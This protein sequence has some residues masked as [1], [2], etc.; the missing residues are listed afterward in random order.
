MIRRKLIYCFSL[1]LLAG[2]AITGTGKDIQE[3]YLSSD[4]E[5]YLS[6]ADLA[7]IQPGLQLKIQ[8][9]EVSGSDV[10]VTFRISD[11]QDQPL[12]RLGIETPGSVSTSFL[13][14]RIKPGDTQYTSY[15]TNSVGQASTDAGGSYTSVGDGVYKYKFGTTLPSG[16]PANATH[17][18]GMYAVRDLRELADEIGLFQLAKTG[19]YVAN[20]TFNFVP[21]GGEVTQ[22]RDVVRTGVCNLCHD[23]LALH[24]GSRQKTEVCILCHQPQT[25]DPDTGNTV[26]FKV[27]IHKIHRGASLPSVQAGTPY[28]IIGYRDSVHDYSEIHWPQDTRN[29]TTCH[30][31]GTQ[32]DNWKKNPTRVA[33]GS[34]HDNVN[35]ATGANHVG[36]P[37][38]DDSKCNI[39][40]PADTGLEFD[41]SV[42]G[43]HTIPEFSKQLA[44]VNVKILEV[45]NT[46]PGDKPKV[47]FTVTDNAGKPI[48][49]T[50]LA[51][52]SLRLAGPTTDHKWNASENALTATATSTGYTYTFATNALPTDASGS[53]VVG[54]E[55]AR[56]VTLPGPLLGQSFSVSERAYNP[57][58]YFGVGGSKVVPRRVVVDIKNCNTCHKRLALHGGGRLN[59]DYC[60]TCHNPATTDNPNGSRSAGFNVP[61]GIP[62]QSIN[63]R[64]MIH[65]IH[66]GHDLEND[67]TVYRSRGVYNFNEIHFPGD[68]RNCAK[69]HVNDSY[70]LPLPA[71]MANTLAPREFYSP[72][73]PA[74]SACL[75][76]HDS[77]DAA[78]HAFLQTA[79]F[80]ESCAACHGEGKEFAVS[81]AH[82]R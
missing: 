57:T 31:Q 61:P 74:A 78:A 1:L 67:F 35:F 75:G 53:Y 6:E 40:H 41:L 60:V 21:S 20:W 16:Y 5:F 51:S 69:C 7:W 70:E 52:L 50:S 17:T 3:R 32:S 37:Q 19:R 13:L 14:A 42:A 68:R 26:D 36:G 4:K 76:C 46:K 55:A 72:L 49:L 11:N 58:F 56:A 8:K 62:A 48:A 66:T 29:C 71:G 24:G 23:P 43:A 30:Q 2:I 15:R 79:P 22:V 34:C 59:P 65:R 18:V 28:Q 63:F 25:T 64:F 39:C 12:D 10:T 80:G 33:C 81:R 44:G 82:A 27:M 73:G 54:A 47:S 9:V 45:T 38:A 77:Q